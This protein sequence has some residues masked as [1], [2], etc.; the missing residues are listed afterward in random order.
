MNTDI[1]ET[2]LAEPPRLKD[3]QRLRETAAMAVKQ[4]RGDANYHEQLMHHYRAQQR[5]AELSLADYDAQIKRHYGST[6]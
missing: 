1:L 4:F 3:L 6:P 5:L 2:M